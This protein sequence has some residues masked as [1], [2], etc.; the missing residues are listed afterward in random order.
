MRRVCAGLW[1]MKSN[2]RSSKMGAI[3]PVS[4]HHK[5]SRNPDLQV[6]NYTTVA[7][8]GQASWQKK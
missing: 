7:R 8:Y 1:L 5:S 2:E 6:L 4:D 3:I